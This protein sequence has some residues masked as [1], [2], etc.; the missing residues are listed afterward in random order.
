M[1]PAQ[2]FRYLMLFLVIVVV[3]DFVFGTVI[4]KV[5]MQANFRY[6]RLYRSDAA[7]D[8]VILGNSR[9]KQGFHAPS[10]EAALGKKVINLSYD[11]ISPEILEALLR[12]YVQHN[13]KP[14]LALIEVSSIRFPPNAMTDLKPFVLKSP[15]LSEVYKREHPYAYGGL[16]VS[17]LFRM[18]SEG[19]LRGLYSLNQSDQTWVQK[20]VIATDLL[21]ATEKAKEFPFPNMFT[22]QDSEERRAALE[23]ANLQALKNIVAFAADQHM[24]IKFVIAPYLPAMRTK[25]AEWNTTLT[26]IRETSNYAPEI[27]DY[28]LALE[29]TNDFADTMH[30]NASGAQHL[31]EKMQTDGCYNT[32]ET[33]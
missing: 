17:R 26:K 12:D 10:I 5:L 19:L 2:P 29:E 14:K 22:K 1:A 30:L 18:N 21:Q 27:L 8:I 15:G 4:E 6:S 24:E 11:G 9:G 3:G 13:G 28:S 7:A 32:S 23:K 16:L 20:R 33:K 31:L 25:V